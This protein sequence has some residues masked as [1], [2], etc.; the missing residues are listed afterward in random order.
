VCKNLSTRPK[1][2]FSSFKIIT[3]ST[4]TTDDASI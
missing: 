3:S 1:R 2:K 4:T